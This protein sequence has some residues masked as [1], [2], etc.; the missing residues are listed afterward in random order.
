LCLANDSNIEAYIWAGI[1][2]FHLYIQIGSGG[3]VEFKKLQRNAKHVRRSHLNAWP[4]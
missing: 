3:I 4:Y 1:Y 2:V